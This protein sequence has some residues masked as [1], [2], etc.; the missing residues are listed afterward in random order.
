MTNLKIN[1]ENKREFEIKLNCWEGHGKKRIYINHLFLDKSDKLFLE[2]DKNGQVWPILISDYYQQ[3]SIMF[4]T[5][6]NDKINYACN[7]LEYVE[8]KLEIKLPD[9]FEEAFNQFSN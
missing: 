1:E 8:R 2:A 5:G 7:M 4:G 3:Y 9:L 6:G